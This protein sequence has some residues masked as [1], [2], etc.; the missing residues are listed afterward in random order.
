MTYKYQKKP[1]K[2]QQQQKGFKSSF[3]LKAQRDSGLKC[4]NLHV[5]CNML[6]DVVLEFADVK[7]VMDC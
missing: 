6:N 5:L 1:Q 2:Q 3:F 7:T 4:P